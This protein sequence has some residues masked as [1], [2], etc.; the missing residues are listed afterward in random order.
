MC[1]EHSSLQA[2]VDELR[3][4]MRE[5]MTEN[6][7]LLHEVLRLKEGE[8]ARLNELQSI[9]K[10]IIDQY[11][12]AK[13]PLLRTSEES[14]KEEQNTPASGSQ[15]LGSE[16]KFPRF[17]AS[18]PTSDSILQ[19]TLTAEHPSYFPSFP[20]RGNSGFSLMG[21]ADES[22]RLR[23]APQRTA[24]QYSCLRN[25]SFVNSRHP[26]HTESSESAGRNSFG[27]DPGLKRVRQFSSKHDAGI[28]AMVVSP[29]PYRFANGMIA[30]GG[31]EGNL[32]VSELQCERQLQNT[33]FHTV[34]PHSDAIA[35]L[36]LS[37]DQTLALCA[38]TDSTLYLVN[39]RHKKGDGALKGHAALISG[40]A[41]CDSAP[42]YTQVYSTSLDRSVRM[43]DLEHGSCLASR[44]TDSAICC[45]CKSA[46]RRTIVTGHRDGTVK[47]WTAEREGCRKVC[48][49]RIHED[50]VSG[51]G[52]SAD[53]MNLI[54]QGRDSALRI[55]EFRTLKIL[56]TLRAA[57]LY[58]NPRATPLFSPDQTVVVGSSAA[59]LF[60]D[61]KSH[62]VPVVVDSEPDERPRQRRDSGVGERALGA[63]APLERP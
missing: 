46:D 55:L 47:I 60:C 13:M 30:T 38:C 20:K 8:G 19:P 3:Q 5:K 24:N 12:N 37:P 51:I 39:L 2:A 61:G 26:S 42:P 9:Y 58:G 53:G 62:L 10:S 56:H 11:P 57:G 40:C 28:N 25:S 54:S 6:D 17:V 41:F 44:L 45:S 4:S 43:W 18:V 27:R 49:E 22:P 16:E 35:A 15:N 52:F 29:K 32:I 7:R 48:D 23:A 21:E 31:I 1:G 59:N 33:F 63:S 50:A 34:S 14:R 36:D